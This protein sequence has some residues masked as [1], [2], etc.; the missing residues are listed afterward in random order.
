M[1]VA[2]VA[3]LTSGAAYFAV[4]VLFVGRLEFERWRRHVLTVPRGSQRRRLL[5]SL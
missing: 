4:P 1:K 3:V 5:G 2:A